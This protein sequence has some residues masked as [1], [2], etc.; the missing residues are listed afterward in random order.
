MD[1]IESINAVCTE[2]YKPFLKKYF[3]QALKITLCH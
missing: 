2:F 3:F 1:K